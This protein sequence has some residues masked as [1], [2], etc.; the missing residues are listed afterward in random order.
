M[1]HCLNLKLFGVLVASNV[2]ISVESLLTK[3]TMLI[4]ARLPKSFNLTIF[5][6]NELKTVKFL[7]SYC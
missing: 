5:S 2:I 3:M 6:S 4:A 1:L 7:G